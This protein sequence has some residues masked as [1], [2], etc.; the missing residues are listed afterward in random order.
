[1]DFFKTGLVQVSDFIRLMNNENP[2]TTT[3]ISDASKTMGYS[4]GGGLNKTSTFD[5]KFS[6]VQSIGLT[7]SRKYPD[8]IASFRAACSPGS[9]KVTFENFN[10]FVMRENALSGFNLT[11]PLL[12]KLFSELDPHK[13]GHL[14][15]ND[16]RNAFIALTRTTNS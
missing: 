1:M 8:L 6:A 14:N 13:K 15:Q 12:Q 11:Q 2:Y 4:L 16:W 3:N 5:W 10:S 9:D 7:L